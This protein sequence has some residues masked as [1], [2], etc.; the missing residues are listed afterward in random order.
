MSDLV[1]IARDGD[2]AHVSLHRPEVKNALN[3]ALI[4]ALI[5]TLEEVAADDAIA[6]V[7]LSGVGKSFCAGADVGWMHRSGTYDREQR[8]AD[9]MP[10][11]RM[12]CALEQLPQTTIARVHGPVYGGGIG[13]VAACDIAIGSWDSKFCFSEVRLGIVP[14]MVAPYA[15]RAIGERAARR[16]FQTAEVF[17]ASDAKRL[18]LLH[19]L[20]PSDQLD[21]R[22]A[23]LLKQLRSAAPF[24]RKVAKRSIADFRGRSFDPDLMSEIAA[25]VAD[26]RSGPEAVEGFSAFL[27]KREACWH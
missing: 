22:I 8:I 4:A 5:H 7:V 18:G 10:L 6:T 16:Y 3:E 20:V 26:V 21:N 15:L 13:L 2:V 23:L 24:A 17:D 9:L 1:Q 25:L 12:L 11:G 14:G 19:E 27:E